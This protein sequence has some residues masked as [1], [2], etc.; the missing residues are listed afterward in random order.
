MN[1]EANNERRDGY[2]GTWRDRDHEH[3]LDSDHEPAN[4][5][6][7]HPYDDNESIPDLIEIDAVRAPTPRGGLIAEARMAIENIPYALCSAATACL[8]YVLRSDD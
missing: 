2:D 1:L 5:P 4:L 3:D 7:R 6:N 8:F